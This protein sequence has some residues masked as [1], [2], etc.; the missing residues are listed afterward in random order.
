MPTPTPTDTVIT[1]GWDQENERITVTPDPAY[2]FRNQSVSWEPE[3]EGSK[4]AVLFAGDSI[5]S[6][7]KVL[8]GVGRPTELRVVDQGPGDQTEFKYLVVYEYAA[9]MFAMV[10]PIIVLTDIP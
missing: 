10:D 2:G 6:E 8:F 1:I 3:T 9:G 4:F 7:N 5:C